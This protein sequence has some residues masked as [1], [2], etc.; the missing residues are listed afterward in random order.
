VDAAANV[1]Q[2]AVEIRTELERAISARAFA[3]YE[4]LAAWLDERGY[5]ISRV[6]PP[7]G[8]ARF[9]RRVEELRLATE[10]ARALATAS[11]DEA[12]A[13]SDALNRLVQ[14]RLF[15]VL[16]ECEEE[17][18][19]SALSRVARAIGELSRASIGQKK[20]AAEARERVAAAQQKVAEA[21]RAG[22][23][24]AEAER[25]LRRALSEIAP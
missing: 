23:L 19:S 8:G 6:A 9:D 17:L 3:G 14:E 11:S 2:L 1:G 21:A 12:G 18:D 4:E 13:L 24:S 5:S 15:D 25:A 7:R 20:W 22:G 10:Q 16:V